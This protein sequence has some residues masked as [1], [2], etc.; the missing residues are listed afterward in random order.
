MSMLITWRIYSSQYISIFLK[1]S[2]EW[3]TSQFPGTYIIEGH[4]F[5]YRV[6]AGLHQQTGLLPNVCPHQ[7]P[8]WY[9]H[10]M[11][12]HFK[13]I[14]SSSIMMDTP[15]HHWNCLVILFD[16]YP[17]A[18]YPMEA[19]DLHCSPP[20]RSWYSSTSHWDHYSFASKASG[21]D[22]G[23]IKGSSYLPYVRIHK[24]NYKA[25]YKANE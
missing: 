18:T 13:T 5:S 23:L 7:L 25:N 14:K 12:H 16:A 15:I 4:H 1:P 17:V 24:A 20:T 10:G 21:E 6:L 3:A 9:H 22:Q 2:E 8:I 11:Y 19:I